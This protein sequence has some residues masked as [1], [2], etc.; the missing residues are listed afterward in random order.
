MCLSLDEVNYRSWLF[1][2][3]GVSR[4]TV[5]WESESGE[6]VVSSN[7]GEENSK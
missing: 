5:M 2:R 3:R 1:L 7:N 6:R 4:G